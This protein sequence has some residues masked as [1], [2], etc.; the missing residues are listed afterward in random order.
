MVYGRGFLRDVALRVDSY[1]ALLVM[2]VGKHLY[3]GYFY[4]AV[5]QDIGAGGFKVEKHHRFF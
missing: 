2:A 3:H 5:I 1:S 4:Y